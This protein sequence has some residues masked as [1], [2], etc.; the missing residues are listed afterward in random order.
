MGPAI[1]TGCATEQR[2]RKQGEC[3]RAEY[4]DAQPLRHAI[5]QCQHVKG[6]RKVKG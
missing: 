3:S 4:R 1:D 5:A 6:G 2:D